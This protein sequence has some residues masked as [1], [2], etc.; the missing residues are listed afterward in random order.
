MGGTSAG[1]MTATM[2]AIYA[3]NGSVSPVKI[4]GKAKEGK[5]NLFYDSWVVMDDLNVS[6]DREPVRLPKM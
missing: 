4:P 3:L 1:G 2:A 5:G 6:D